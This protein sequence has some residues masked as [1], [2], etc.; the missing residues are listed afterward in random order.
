MI[1]SAPQRNAATLRKVV[2]PFSVSHVIVIDSCS[3]LSRS[4]SF[5][6]S[7]FL[8]FIAISDCVFNHDYNKILE[9]DWL[10]PALI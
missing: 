6:F 8:D 9:T 7:L 5:F 1:H 10:S 3:L 2:A 4:F